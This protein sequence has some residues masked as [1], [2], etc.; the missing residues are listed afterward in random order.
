MWHKLTILARSM[1]TGS[2]ITRLCSLALVC[3]LAFWVGVYG[4]SGAR[5][6]TEMWKTHDGPTA[7]NG[8]VCIPSMLPQWRFGPFWTLSS[9]SLTIKKLDFD[10]WNTGDNTEGKPCGSC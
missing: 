8:I 5:A 9:A 10:P 3:S 2:W 7:F 4:T 1:L 6:I